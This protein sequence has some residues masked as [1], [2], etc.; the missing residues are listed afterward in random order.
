MTCPYGEITTEGKNRC[1]DEMAV[2]RKSI[3]AA[4]SE[5]PKYTEEG[6]RID[7]FDR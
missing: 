2:N 4:G 1:F 6:R 7:V 5:D 3:R